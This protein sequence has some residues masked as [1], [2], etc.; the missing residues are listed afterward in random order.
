MFDQ[1][2][3]EIELHAKSAQKRHEVAAF[4]AIH[5]G[6]GFVQQEKPRP[7]GHGPGDFEP[8]LLP[9]GQAASRLSTLVGE[10]EQV[11]QFAGF[12]RNL[13]F[14]IPERP[15]A[16]KRVGDPV[17]CPMV[18]SDLDV[19]LDGHV[20]EQSDVLEGAGHAVFSDAVRGHAV[21]IVSGEA[22]DAGGWLVEAGQKV[23]DRGFAGPVRPDQ[24]DEFPGLEFEVEIRDGAKSAEGLGE[25][26]D[27][28]NLEIALQP[29]ASGR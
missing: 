7:G 24:P 6:D 19:V 3:R 26:L 12:L 22:D 10:A 29:V 13:G 18:E 20:P 15:S 8:S 28:Q 27:A 16:Q 4:A 25:F 14:R 1:K 11:K 9:V 5:T 21:N 17:A 23:E 2:H